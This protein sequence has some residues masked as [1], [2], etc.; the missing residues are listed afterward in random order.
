MSKT[1]ER[2][3]LFLSDLVTVNI[4][5]IVYY[6]I[7]VESG[8][9]SYANPPSFLAPLVVI[10]LYWLIIFSFAGLYQ[11]WFARSRFDEFTLVFKAVTFG[12]MFLF[13][14][15][16]ID[17]FLSNAPA[18]S[19]FLIVI[20]GALMVSLVGGG[21]IVIRS[22][23][24]N[25]LGKGIGLRNTLVVG[26]GSKA[27]QLKAMVDRAPELGYKVI[28]FISTV[29]EQIAGSLGTIREMPSI[30]KENDVIEVLIALEPAEKERLFEV[31][32]YCSD[33]RISTKIL[34]DMYEIVSGM[35]KTSQIY[36]VPLIEV[37]AVIMPPAAMLMKR[38]IDVV[39][40]VL[41]LLF[42]APFMILSVLIIKL[43]S[44][45]PVF[46]SQVR[47]GR[48]GRQ[49]VM[50]KIRTMKEGAE[51]E[52][53][54]WTSDNDI[55]V[56]GYGR[57]LRRTRL[58][59]LPQ[60]INVLKNEMSIVG[61]RPERPH[62]VEQLKEQIPYYYKRMLIKP[63]ITGWAQVKHKY[64]SSFDDVRSKLQYDF[65]YIENMSLKLDFKIMVNTI[66]VM[67]RMKGI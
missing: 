15:I 6:L 41:S 56:T 17:D 54:D 61:P 57:F 16:F 53:P 31:L 43:S 67:I 8:W 55:R 19:R 9:I 25:L 37:A 63:G 18:I 10:Y 51:T 24:K 35:A 29:E 45:G 12:C 44:K 22:I 3:L 49:F 21:R 20:Y 59:E 58:D 48:K 42:F 14:V 30:T 40:S 38:V 65:F 34:P 11:Y 26:T 7:R 4:A 5:W 2:I 27:L 64:D 36:G 1:S 13:F 46:Y 66:F 62:I 39:I 32:R 47:A 23:Q 28:G 50:Y 33:E 52:G 60:M